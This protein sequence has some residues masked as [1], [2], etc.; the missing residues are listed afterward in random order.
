MAVTLCNIHGVLCSKIADVHGIEFHDVRTLKF[1]YFQKIF[2]F[3]LHT[4]RD[5]TKGA[6]FP[7][8]RITA[9]SQK[10]QHC[11]KQFFK[12]VHLLPKHLRFEHGG[13]KLVSCPRRRLTSLRPCTSRLSSQNSEICLQKYLPISSKL[14]ITN[15]L[16]QNAVDYRNHFTIENNLKVEKK[17]CYFEN[18]LLSTSEN[19]W[20]GGEKSFLIWDQSF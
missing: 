4:T 19:A 3:L 16:K 5:V 8:C 14:S 18:K 7:G 10:S 17:V 20:V 15:N 9:G 6:Q 11:H 12:T 2:R 13:A 1:V